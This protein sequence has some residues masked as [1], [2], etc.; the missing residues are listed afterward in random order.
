MVEKKAQALK[1]PAPLQIGNFLPEFSQPIPGMREAE[2]LVRH[3]E[4]QSTVVFRVFPDVR[5]AYQNRECQIVRGVRTSDL[6]SIEKWHIAVEGG[7]EKHPA[8]RDV[9]VAQD[10]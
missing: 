9:R 10:P 6:P 7:L 3:A 5:L 8:K 2:A 1:Y 4:E